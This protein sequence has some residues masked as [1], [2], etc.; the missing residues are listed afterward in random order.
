MKD[1]ELKAGEVVEE[2]SRANGKYEIRCDK[3]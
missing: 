3:S 1:I 2:F